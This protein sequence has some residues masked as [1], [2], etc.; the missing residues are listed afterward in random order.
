MSKSADYTSQALL[1][2]QILEADDGIEKVPSER[3]LIL[4]EKCPAKPTVSE[5]K[6]TLGQE[7][8]KPSHEHVPLNPT[9]PDCIDKSSDQELN[10]NKNV[11]SPKGNLK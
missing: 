6:A 9:D 3:N 4:M 8:T 11:D 1:R 7:E 2:V 5:D 10:S